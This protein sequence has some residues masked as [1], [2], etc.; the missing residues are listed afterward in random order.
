MAT[1]QAFENYQKFLERKKFYMTF[2]YD[3]DKERNFVLAQ[4]N[5]IKGR[6]L[7]AGT[8]K[9][10]FAVPLA[11]SGYSFVAFDISEEDMRLAKLN[12]EYHELTQNV[13]FKIENA[14]HTNFADSSFDTIFSINTLHHFEKPYNVLD[15]FIRILSLNGRI[16]LSDFSTEG[17]DVIEKIHASEGNTHSRGK[18]SISEAAGYFEQRGF[19]VKRKSSAHQDVLV[20]GKE[21]K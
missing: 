11:K 6:I 5:P 8:G 15:E 7:E 20:I 3:I 12:L 4:A 18:M 21:N 16:I 19:T 14:E 9:G 2:G 17:F 10:S 13:D 1:Q